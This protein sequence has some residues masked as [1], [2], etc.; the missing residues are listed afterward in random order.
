MIVRSQFS[1]I[2]H[3]LNQHSARSGYSHALY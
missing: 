3:H 2:I 1:S